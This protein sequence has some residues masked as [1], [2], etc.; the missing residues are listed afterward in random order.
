MADAQ[1]VQG[2]LL[3]FLRETASRLRKIAI[4]FPDGRT[5]ILEIVQR[6]DGEAADLETIMVNS[7]DR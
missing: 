7:K 6:I 5:A 2:E 1:K 3:R 4:E